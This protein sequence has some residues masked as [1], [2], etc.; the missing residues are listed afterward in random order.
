MNE[1]F[2]R[3]ADCYHAYVLRIILQ[4]EFNIKY[5]SI[6]KID[7]NNFNSKPFD[8]EN[9]NYFARFGKLLNWSDYH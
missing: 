4:N 5:D 3:S 8:Y 9:I 6:K 2:S 1:T 7:K